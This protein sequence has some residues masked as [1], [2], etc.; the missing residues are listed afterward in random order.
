MPRAIKNLDN[1]RGPGPALRC[2]QLQ[3]SHVSICSTL[4]C[5]SRIQMSFLSALPW[6]RAARTDGAG[7]WDFEGWV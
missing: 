1:R 7:I 2:D 3:G 4:K 6:H 5:G